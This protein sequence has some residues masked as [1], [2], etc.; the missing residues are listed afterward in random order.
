MKLYPRVVLL[1]H[2]S[3]WLDNE[4]FPT[5]L[6]N[7]EENYQLAERKLTEMD[8]PFYKAQAAFFIFANFEKVRLLGRKI[9]D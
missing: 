1:V 7:L 2:T 4:Y 3:D 9:R 6:K 8:V 5:N